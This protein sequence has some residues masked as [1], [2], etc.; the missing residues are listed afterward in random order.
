[1]SI[2]TLAVRF[3]PKKVPPFSLLSVPKGDI[4]KRYKAHKKYELKDGTYVV[5][6]TTILGILAKKALIP[7]ANKLGLDG[8]NYRK[9]LD[10]LADIGTLAHY[11]VECDVK[12]IP[13]DIKVTE[14]YSQNQYKA[15]LIC[16]QKFVVW[17][18]EVGFEPIKSE[19][20]FSSEKY[21]YGGTLDL[22]GLRHGKKTLI[23]FKTGGAIYPEA[24]TQ[25]ASYRNL[26][27]EQGLEVEEC[28]I[29]RIGRNENEGFEDRLVPNVPL[30]FKRFLACLSVYNVNKELGLK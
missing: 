13:P 27:T 10:E 18:Q 26:A 29:V 7:W 22:Y 8:I 4:M 20:G 2:L 24:F 25:V 19:L 3:P 17:K 16:Y 15:A 12:G 11:M 1:M 30:H 9:Y 6:A 21:R 5:G 14:D 28:R 23:D